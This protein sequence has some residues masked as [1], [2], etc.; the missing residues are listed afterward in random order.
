VSS[1]LELP[2]SLAAPC[3]SCCR[4]CSCGLLPCLWP[5]VSRSDTLRLFMGDAAVVVGCSLLPEFPTSRCINSSACF[6]SWL[7]MEVDAK[8]CRDYT[9][10]S[11][12]NTNTRTT[13]A[14]CTSPRNVSCNRSSRKPLHDA[15]FMCSRIK[16]GCLQECSAC[17]FSATSHRES[18]LQSYVQRNKAST[19]MLYL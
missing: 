15:G 9:L 10:S 14:L 19:W 16:Q 5:L 13:C 6:T 2:S 8:G 12:T 18:R 7:M 17:S 3:I 11:F 1:A 4:R